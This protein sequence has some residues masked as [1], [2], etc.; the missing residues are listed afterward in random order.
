MRDEVQRRMVRNE[1]LF[2]EAN[3]GIRNGLWPEA[4]DRIVRF[5]CE[6]AHLEC[7][8]AV[9]VSLADYE[10][11]RA[12]PHQFI[13]LPGHEIAEVESLVRREPG[14]VVVEK[15]GAATEEADVLNPRV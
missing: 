11:V 2:R 12:R 15:Q 9:E 1:A 13:C 14:Y 5:R 10:A 7:T 3:E 4:P 8:D 6:C